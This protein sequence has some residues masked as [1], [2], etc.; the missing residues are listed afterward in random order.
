[1]LCVVL[2]VWEASAAVVDAKLVCVSTRK[3]RAIT[4]WKAGDARMTKGPIE[5][6]VFLTFLD[7]RFEVIP[8]DELA[9]R[10][11]T[12]RAATRS[13]AK[14]SEDDKD[15]IARSIELVRS[16]DW[17]Q[18]PPKWQAY[19]DASRAWSKASANYMRTASATVTAK[20]A[21]ETAA[22]IAAK[23]KRAG[24]VPR[25]QAA[26]VRA[27]KLTDKAK[28][29][30][31]QAIAAMDLDLRATAAMVAATDAH[32]QSKA[33]ERRELRAYTAQIDVAQAR[34]ERSRARSRGKEFDAHQEGNLARLVQEADTRMQELRDEDDASRCFRSLGPV[35]RVFNM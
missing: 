20:I 32:L 6:F 28:R 3:D 16:A 12:Y 11:N 31:Q 24:D 30:T 21:A 33:W 4:L 18:F 23:T 15:E 1:M 8:A 9:C 26:K 2:R 35:W 13:A 22:A 27:S 29:L 10:G 19:E 25:A 5:K 14:L 34:V 7:R 17:A